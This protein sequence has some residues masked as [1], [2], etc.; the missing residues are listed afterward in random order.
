MRLPS[1]T[2]CLLAASMAFSQTNVLDLI[3]LGSTSSQFYE[4]IVQNEL[5]TLIDDE[6]GLTLF[7]PTNDAL[8]SYAASMDMTFEEFVTSES[9]VQMAQYHLLPND[10][11]LF[12][13][14]SGEITGLT[15]LGTYLNLTV[16]AGQFFANDTEVSGA[17]LQAN[18][19]VIH[20]VEEVIEVSEGIYQWLDGSSQHNYLTV[21]MG[22]LGLVD[23]FSTFGT[24][25]LF[26]PTDVAILAYAEENDMSIVDVV[27]NP[28]FISALLLHSITSTMSS[29]EDLVAMES[30]TADS[31][32]VL[33]ISENAE[34]VV[35]V[36]SA[37][38]TSADNETQNG[39]VHVVDEVIIPS[40]FLSDA[41]TD[42]GL[43]LL[44]TLLEA[45]GLINELNV[46][47]SLTLFAPTNSAI[48]SFLAEN[49]W[50]VEE[51]LADVEGSGATEGLLYH[52]LGGAYYAADLSDGMVLN[53][54]SGEEAV[55]SI[56]GDSV[57][58]SASMSMVEIPD[59]AADN[60]VM[61]IVDAILLPASAFEG[62]TDPDACNYDANATADDGSCDYLAYE[63]NIQDN[64]C[65]GGEEGAITVELLDGS[66]VVL[67]YTLDALD[68][69]EPNEDWIGAFGDLA[70]GTYEL[71]IYGEDCIATE[72]IVITEPSGM[73]LEVSVEAVADDGSGNGSAEATVTGGTAPYDI[74][75]YDAD[76]AS[77]ANSQMVH[78]TYFVSVTDALG[79]TVLLNVVIE[80]VESVSSPV[81]SEETLVAYPNPTTGLLKVENLH[82]NWRTI[83]AVN[84]VG[85]TVHIHQRVQNSSATID[86]SHLESGIYILQVN[87]GDVTERR[88]VTVIVR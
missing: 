34:G 85:Q 87:G 35:N 72:V 59:V 88:S 49:E 42:A 40:Y 58:V 20:Y 55:V 78:G 66:L 7:V 22:S 37:T 43:T 79:C 63:I 77:V 14:V 86:V 5:D 80:L 81:E 36:N 11:V 67:Y 3:S 2:F 16:G 6:S 53:M 18:N 44:D 19:G 69:S 46:P 13:E 26:A 54:L 74:V 1:L 39:Y 4:V 33:Y 32:E 28:D 12:S 8:D 71:G 25:T 9:A 52:V 68:G 56:S 65:T 45:T 27:Y 50:T 84:E 51:I 83:S 10:E 38:V 57:L 70:A 61:H 73:A 48:S 30:V 29:A 75:W 23:A 21:A 31:D 60:G 64:V 17:D 47:G 15:A 76:G 24:R 62:C 41:I 82:Q